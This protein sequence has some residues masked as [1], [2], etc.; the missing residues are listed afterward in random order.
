MPQL[1]GLC[2]RANPPEAVYCYFDG[3]ELS[4][5]HGDILSTALLPFPQPLQFPSGQ[6]CLNFEQLIR[7]CVADWPAAVRMLQQGQLELFL[8][9]LGRI[10]LA[11]IARAAARSS[12][13]DRAL[14]EL[15]AKLPARELKPAQLQ[16]SPQEIDLGSLRIGEDRTVELQLV[17]QGMRLV[18]GSVTSETVWLA[19]GDGEP[20]KVF[21][22]STSQTIP[23]RIRGQALR[24]G[25]KPLQGH[26]LVES[27][28]GGATVSIK[29]TVPVA[30]FAEDVFAGLRSPRQIVEKSR[31]SPQEAALLFESG[32]VAA[33]YAQNGWTYPIQGPQASGLDA[34]RQFFKALGLADE[35]ATA[36]GVAPGPRRVLPFAKGSLAGALSP[37]QLVDRARAAPQEAAALIEAGAVAS[38]FE[39]NGWPYPVKGPCAMGLDALRQLLKAM[40]LPD[41]FASPP[42]PRPV[43]GPRGIQLHGKVGERLRYTLEARSK[44]KS[45]PATRAQAVSDQGWLSVGS[46][47]LNGDSATI[48]LVVPSVPDCPGATLQAHVQVTVNDNQRFVVPVTLV[49]GLQP[50]RADAALEI[51]RS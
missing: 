23:I 44:D 12:D 32:A 29:A 20:R 4:S 45:A 40:G 15:L 38:W 10:D 22:F 43:S 35:F 46:T 50:P 8:S 42:L 6:T 14:D 33:W 1:C 24:A 28:G 11:M 31:G 26:L 49:V 51:P 48:L 2:S 18:H 9:E 13:S 19:L 7:C 41:D 34:L 37:Q 21:Q 17:N 27:N 16:V 5:N 39:Q 36:V 30:T 3:C 25:P 47:R